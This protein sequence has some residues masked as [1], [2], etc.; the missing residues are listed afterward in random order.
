MTRAIARG[1]A[2]AG[3]GSARRV[4]PDLFADDTWHYLGTRGVQLARENGALA[5]LPLALNNLAHL[6]CLEGDLDGSGGAARRGRCHRGRDRHRT[7]S[8]S[9][10]C[11]WPAFAGSRR[12][13]WSC[14]TRPS[15]PRSPRG[16]GVV[17]TFSEHARAV[18]YNGLGRYEAALAP[19][20]A[21]ANGMSCWSR[22]GRCPSSSRP[23]RAAARPTSRTPRSSICRSEQRAAGTELALGIE[24]R[25]RALLSDGALAEGLYREAIDRLGR[26]RVG[27]RAGPR[28]SAVRRMAT[29]RPTPNR[30]P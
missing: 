4:A 19:L 27:A 18:L 23:R 16:E 14:S 17:L 2:S 11:R 8:T 22:C 26:T 12:R 20:K 29:A 10:D 25:S 28:S 30:R 13:R 9:G 7:D 21:R 15:R 3:L 24:A 5:V 6:R 1:K